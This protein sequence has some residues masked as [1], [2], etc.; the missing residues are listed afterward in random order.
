VE[1]LKL[2]IKSS[3]PMQIREAL[4]KLSFYIS[5]IYDN[6]KSF[7]AYSKFNDDWEIVRVSFS[8][9]AVEYVA[10]NLDGQHISNGMSIDD[11][12]KWMEML[13]NESEIDVKDC[14]YTCL[15]NLKSNLCQTKCKAI[16]TTTQNYSLSLLQLKQRLIP[17]LLMTG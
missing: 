12:E 17:Q 10:V 1:F 13:N 5:L 6:E 3:K 16:A 8:P 4:Y 15:D 9:E 7:L 2:S 11:F 14:N